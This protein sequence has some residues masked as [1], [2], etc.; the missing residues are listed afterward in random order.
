MFRNNG[1]V[2]FFAEFACT[3]M[4]A[5]SEAYNLDDGTELWTTKL[6]AVGGGCHSAYMNQINMGMGPGIIS[7]HG[8]EDLGDYIEVLDQHTGMCLAHKVYRRLNGS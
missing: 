5:P 2:L 7:I 6:R 3:P 8:T 1:N 4:V